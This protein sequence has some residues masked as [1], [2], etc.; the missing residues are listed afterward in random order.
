MASYHLDVPVLTSMKY[1]GL[2]GVGAI[3][4]RGA[5]CIINDMWDRKLDKAVGEYANFILFP[6]SGGVFRDLEKVTVL[7]PCGEGR[8]NEEQALG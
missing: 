4:M 1:L 8:P 3:I 5:G 2:F 7:I 6:S